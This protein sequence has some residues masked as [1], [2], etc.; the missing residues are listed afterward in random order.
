MSTNNTGAGR[1]NKRGEEIPWTDDDEAA[2]DCALA[3][4]GPP[5]PDEE[6]AEAEELAGVDAEIAR[7][8]EALRC[9][10]WGEWEDPGNDQEEPASEA[11]RK[12]MDEA[13]K[14]WDRPEV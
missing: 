9:G 13:R 3:E 6:A 4:L 10:V 2:A 11:G 7:I 12:R 14:F 8:E 5:D 1:D